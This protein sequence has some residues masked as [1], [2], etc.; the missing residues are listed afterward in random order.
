MLAAYR[1][2][3]EEG[4]TKT[5]SLL[6]RLELIFCAQLCLYEVDLFIKTYVKGT[7]I[8]V[9]IEMVYKK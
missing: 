2:Q 6:A 3:N 7:L 8:G 4:T 9:Y 5:G 1:R